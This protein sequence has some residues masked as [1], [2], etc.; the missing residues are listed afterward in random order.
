MSKIA[1]TIKQ[2]KEEHIGQTGKRLLLVE[3][4]DTM[5]L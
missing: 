4:S 1:T 2:I 3:G 5:S